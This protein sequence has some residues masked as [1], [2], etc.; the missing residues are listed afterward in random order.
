MDAFRL[1]TDRNGCSEPHNMTKH[2]TFIRAIV[3]A[4]QNVTSVT[5]N[6]LLASELMIYGQSF[7]FAKH[8]WQE[9]KDCNSRFIASKS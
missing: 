2:H 3:Q 6:L 9:R 7:L 4:F 8:L 1:N 5:E